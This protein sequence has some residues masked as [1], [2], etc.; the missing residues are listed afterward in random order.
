VFDAFVAYDMNMHGLPVTWQ[1]NVKNLFDKTYY[2]SSVNNLGVQI[3][4]PME[5]VLSA[6][7]SF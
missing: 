1:L 6:R 3:G 2:T 4:D 5:A 7:V